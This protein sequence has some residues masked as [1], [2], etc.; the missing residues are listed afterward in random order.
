M[1]LCLC[2]RVETLKGVQSIPLGHGRNAL[3][4]LFFWEG[5]QLMKNTLMTT[6]L[7]YVSLNILGMSAI[8]IY[9]LADTFFIA[10]GLGPMGLTALNLSISV[11]SILHGTGLMVGI[12]G[13]TR[14]AI[15]QSE[16]KEKESREVFHH[17]LKTGILLGILFM[18]VGIFFAGDLALLLGA[19]AET[20]DM[21][22]T[23]MRMILLFAPLFILNNILLAFVRNDHNP[24]GAMMAMIAGSLSNIVLDYVFMFPLGMGMFGAVLATSLAPLIS[25]LCLYPHFSNRRGL[26]HGFTLGIS[27][28]Q[29]ADHFTLGASSFVVEVSSG[30]VLLI[31]NLV[32]LRLEGNLGVAAYGIVANL[33]LVCLAVFTGLSQGMQ[34]LVSK[35]HGQRNEK[36]VKKVLTYGLVLALGLGILLYGTSLVFSGSLVAVFNGEENLKIAELAERGLKLYFSGLVLAGVNIII[37]TYLSAVE[38]APEGFLLSLLRG[39]FVMV[40]TVMLFS[41]LFFMDGVWMS[42]LATEVLVVLFSVYFLKRRVSERRKERLTA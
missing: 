5:R 26:F 33:A 18:G 36:N 22:K 14:F 29:T 41:R 16:H 20:Y 15:L 11:Y 27:S 23:Y 28:Q 34:P 35:Y 39:V 12:G 38:R 21:A 19:D 1:K 7:R 40:P 31:F 42:F 4:T 2:H 25:I 17:A 32:I 3:D 9:I 24:K 8:S 37:S 30:I 13:A 6:F 10:Q